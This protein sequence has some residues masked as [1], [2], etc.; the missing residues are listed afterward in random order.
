MGV[1]DEKFN[2]MGVPLKIRFLRGV[3]RKTNMPKMGGAWTV[4]RFKKRLDKKEGCGVFEEGLIPQ[5]AL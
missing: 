3:S 2:I 1:K 5:S 4:S